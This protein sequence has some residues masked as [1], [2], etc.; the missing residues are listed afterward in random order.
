MVSSSIKRAKLSHVD[1]FIGSSHGVTQM[2][3][4]PD[5]PSEK[6]QAAGAEPGPVLPVQCSLTTHRLCERLRERIRALRVGPSPTPNQHL[7]QHGANAPRGEGNQQW[8]CGRSE[9]RAR[10]AGSRAAR[11]GGR[12][13]GAGTRRQ[14]TGVACPGFP[15]LGQAAGEKQKQTP[16]AQ[17]P[18][19]N[20]FKP[21]QEN[22]K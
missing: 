20:S 6:E 5:R 16:G 4:R 2:R 18:A 1:R 7:V 17:V 12:A 3:N 11:Q 10:A 14:R 13:E 21:P 22:S 9:A 15:K 19:V 8:A